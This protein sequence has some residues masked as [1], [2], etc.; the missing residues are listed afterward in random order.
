M[1]FQIRFL[2]SAEGKYFYKIVTP[3]WARSLGAPCSYVD[4]E[5]GWFDKKATHKLAVGHILKI[6]HEWLMKLW[7]PDKCKSC[8]EALE[9][10]EI[11]PC[12]RDEE[13]Y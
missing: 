13:L 3:R 12:V 9:T 6:R 4:V 5:A 7:H 10:F 2:K 1:D 11:C 8:G